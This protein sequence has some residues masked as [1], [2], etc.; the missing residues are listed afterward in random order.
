MTRSPQRKRPDSIITFRQLDA[1][2]H[3][4][5]GNLTDQYFDGRTTKKEFNHALDFFKIP[6]ML[7]SDIPY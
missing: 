2:E 5:L 7:E 4:I 1:R 6:A 3:K